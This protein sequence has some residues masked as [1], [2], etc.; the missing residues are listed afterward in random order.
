MLAHCPIMT[1]WRRHRALSMVKL[2]GNRQLSSRWCSPL[3][4]TG[5]LGQNA[6]GAK[7]VIAALLPTICTH[8]AQRSGHA[9][10]PGM[11]E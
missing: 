10:K 2:N 1:E 4:R 5:W 7:F 9:P 3:A 11:T 6:G 8:G